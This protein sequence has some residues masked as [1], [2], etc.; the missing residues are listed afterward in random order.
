LNILVIGGTRFIGP[1]VV[2]ELVEQGSNVTVFHRGKSQAALPEQVKHLYGDRKDLNDFKA[3][4][5]KC[6]PDVVLDMIPITEQQALA[7]VGV[8]KDR[9]KRIVAISSQDVYRAYGVLLGKE[10]G[11]EAQP[12]TESSLLRQKLYP[13]RDEN[14]R[15]D[16]DPRKILDDYDKIPVEKIIMNT[17]GI[18]G[19]VLRLP[20]VYGPNDYQHRLFEYLKRMDDKRPAIILSRE[21]AQWRTSRGFV[22]NVAH[23]IAL[24]IAHDKAENRIYNAA[25]PDDFTE[26]DWIRQIGVA[27]GWKGEVVIVPREKL[28]PEFAAD[29]NAAQHL[30]ADTTRIRNELGYREPIPLQR[31]LAATIEWERANPPVIQAGQF[32]YEKEDEVLKTTGFTV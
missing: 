23:A 31:A 27:A 6:K 4:F 24:A 13:Y 32:D 11:I 18:A 15:A 26:A 22:E 28:P 30:T 10:T 17:P 16:D 9:T 19:T 1:Y 21:M 2:R 20:M 25:E 8:F 12:S 29:F 5:G 14:P 7:L 3:Q